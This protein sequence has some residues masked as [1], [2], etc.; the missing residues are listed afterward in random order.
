MKQVLKYFFNLLVVFL[1]IIIIIIT[2]CI[3][4]Q[5]ANMKNNLHIFTMSS[6]LTFFFLSKIIFK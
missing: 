1:I 2:I 3:C 5:P 4:S 6:I